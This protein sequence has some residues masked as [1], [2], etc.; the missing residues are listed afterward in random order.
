MAI[1]LID[2]PGDFELNNVF[3][4]K[5]EIEAITETRIVWKNKNGESIFYNLDSPDR[6]P[7]SL[8][9]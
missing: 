3:E 4:N 7:A 9:R 8:R 1:K 5:F 2:Y 6:L